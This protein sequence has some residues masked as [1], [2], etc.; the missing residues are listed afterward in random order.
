MHRHQ[1]CR[2]ALAAALRRLQGGRYDGET[3][4]RGNC[5]AVCY[6]PDGHSC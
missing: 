2:H 5:G 6:K 4:V 1:H 3:A